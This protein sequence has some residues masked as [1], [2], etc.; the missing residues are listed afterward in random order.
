MFR[1]SRPGRPRAFTLVELLVVI[2]IIGILVALLLPAIQA[3]RES[4]RRTQCSNHLKQIGLGFQNHHDTYRFFPTAGHSWPNAPDIEGELPMNAPKQRAGWAYQIL[5]FIE[6]DIV[7]RGSGGATLDAMQ[8]N[9]IGAKIS[10]YFCPARRPPQAI[11][12]NSWYGPSGNYPHAM[13][14]YA[15]SNLTNNGVV[16]QTNANQT[17]ANG[18]PISTATITD[19]TSNTLMVG[20]KRL[21]YM[22]LGSIQGDDNEGYTS[23]FDHDVMRSTDREPRPDPNTGD[24]EQRF[25]S[26]H[27]AGFNTVFA[28]GAV[29]FLTWT[30]D[31]TMFHRMGQRSDGNPVA[32]P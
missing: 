25:G 17:W 6:Q 31:L 16:V 7:W 11:S 8:I 22:V 12:A 27:P 5:P 23:G 24:G 28:D 13:I 15:G 2:A 18:A 4:A 20:E 10:T 3:A 21:N 1:L 29:R 19:G 26:L 14:D 9:I 30:I 32:F